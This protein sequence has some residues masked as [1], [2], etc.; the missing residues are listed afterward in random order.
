MTASERIARLI[1]RRNRLWLALLLAVL[2]GL[3][4]GL[5]RLE[6]SSDNRAFFGRENEEYRQLLA[7]DA[8]YADSSGLLFLMVP[9]E[10]TA[11]EPAALEALRRFT[12]AAWQIPYVLRVDSAANQSVS[13]AE[14]DE[15]IV[16]PLLEEVTPEAAARF[17]ERLMGLEEAV[18]RLV[19]EDGSAYGMSVQVVLPEAEG[20]TEEVVGHV[21]A[22][23]EDW[24]ADY[25]G[26]EFRVTGG[27]LGGL[28]LEQVALD[29]LLRLVPASAAIVLLLLVFLMRTLVG[30][31]VT[32]AVVLS[33]TVATLGFAG[34]TGVVLT[35][36]TAISPLS[37]TVLITASS[38]HVMLSWMRKREAAGPDA[39]AEE[40]LAENLGAVTVTN[41]TTAF[42]FLC[43]NFS[44]SPPLRDM[45]NII[46]FGLMVGLAATFVM[47]P[48]GLRFDRREHAGRIPISAAL[49]ERLAGGILR[50]WRWWLW[51]FPLAVVVALT[52]IA[53]IGYDDSIYRYFDDRYEF[54]RAADAITEKLSGLESMQFSFH[55][56]EGANVFDPEF[57]R[58]IDRFSAWLE[59]QP[60]VVSVSSI[61]AI[62]K[63]L[64][65]S[66][67]GGDAAFRTIPDSREANAQLMMFY[68]FS[69]PVG[70]DLTST[71]DV[72]R[73][74][75]RLIA[76]LRVA[77]SN[78]T[79]ALA[80]AAEA[81]LAENEPLLDAPA[82]GLSVAFARLSQRNN[83][84]MLLGL[85][86]VLIL[87]S[88]TMVVT[89][90]SVKYGAISLAPNLVPAVL[91]FGLWGW[92][93]RDVNLGSTVV[94]TMTFG[95]VVDDTVH[96]LMHYLRRKR[97]GLDA[98]AALRDT[99]SVVGAA[100]V[101]TTLALMAGFA[102]MTLSG[103]VINQ[104]IGALTVFVVGFAVLADLLFLPAL[105]YA[106]RGKD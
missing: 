26:W 6:V 19:A 43:L 89:L 13:R 37:V 80:D 71:I 75:T 31:A 58:A 61:A 21:R 46:A 88:G 63:R 76:S 45:G 68:E 95:I 84:Q 12:D 23:I 54:R 15:I 56:P 79:R 100:I 14:G 25:P 35:A 82:S 33:G 28:T 66:M 85:G 49:M 30:A 57:L 70:M 1:L 39:A 86:A 50:R 16:E 59:D 106:F 67:N 77:D 11:F 32:L 90:R 24:R 48:A 103:F 94:T 64:N 93:F 101:I 42:G 38:I 20:T 55:A 99:F 60:E 104:H 22:M 29:D 105:L 87:I 17:E 102:V 34:W 47:L 65:E 10:G 40:A 2:A 72:S 81:W 51:G 73:T 83:Q 62:L 8:T 69:L 44:E 36:G 53:R 4:A 91:A 98:A 78:E 5:P 3:A 92:T 41:L 97:A 74:Q 27:M 9:P 7:L 52:G 96:F 18:G